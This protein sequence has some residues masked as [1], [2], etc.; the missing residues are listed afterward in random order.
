MKVFPALLT[1]TVGCT[2]NAYHTRVPSTFSP[3]LQAAAFAAAKDW[4]ANVP[5]T[6]DVQVAPCGDVA[7]QVCL[8]G[9]G[10]I[11]ALPWEPGNLTGLTINRTILLDTASLGGDTPAARQRLIAHEMGH[12]MGLLH[13]CGNTIMYPY[14]DGG[15]L[16]VTATDAAQWKYVH[17]MGPA[18]SY[19]CNK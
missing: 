17:G 11:P 6:L 15:A 18:V 8:V 7:T 9:V 14:S 13:T 19:N 16:T 2:A 1:M 5:V 10:A 12:A 4:E 3:A